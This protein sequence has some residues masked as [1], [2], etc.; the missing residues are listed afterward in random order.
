MLFVKKYCWALEGKNARDS[1]LTLL[2][3]VKII[4]IGVAGAPD[5]L[6]GGGH[7]RAATICLGN[8]VFGTSP[9]CGVIRCSLASDLNL[10]SRYRKSR[11]SYGDDPILQA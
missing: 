9:Q 1:D 3:C 8:N 11:W 6:W 5:K 2:I 7:C 10:Y 4:C